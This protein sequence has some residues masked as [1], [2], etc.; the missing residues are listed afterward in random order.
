M[1]DHDSTGTLFPRL[2][3]SDFQYTPVRNT[4]MCLMLNR[5]C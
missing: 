4:T 1:A 5:Y 3:L 2:G